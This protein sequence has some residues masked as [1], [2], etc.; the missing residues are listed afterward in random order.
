MSRILVSFSAGLVAW[1]TFLPAQTE[2]KACDEVFGAF[3]PCI[4]WPSF[5]AGL[6]VMIGSWMFLRGESDPVRRPTRATVVSG[7]ALAGLMVTLALFPVV[8]LDSGSCSSWFGYQVPGP[9]W[10]GPLAATATAGLV[11][12]LLGQ[13]RAGTGNNPHR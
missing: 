6:L 3:S 5:L 9:G 13:L 7:S 2:W 4:L 12:L 11:G 8:C 1:W 10:V